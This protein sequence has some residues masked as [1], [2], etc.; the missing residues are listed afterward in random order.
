MRRSCFGPWLFQLSF[1]VAL[2][3]LWYLAT[4]QW[5]VAAILLPNPLRVWNQLALIA[6][7]GAFIH[8]LFVT[9]YEVV[10]AFVIAST[11]GLSIGYG[12]GRSAYAIRVFDPLFTSIYAVPVIL[13]VPLYSLLFGLGSAS[14]IALGVTIS[15]FP[16]ALNTMAGFSATDKVLIKAA[17]SF[18]ASPFHQF[19]Y[20]LLP[21]AF[22]TVLAGLRMG[23]ILAFLAVLGSE[24]LASFAGLGHK[25]VQYSETMETARMYAYI[26]IVV[27]LAGLL[28]FILS[29]VE[30]WGRRRD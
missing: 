26:I 12:V 19:R 7:T 24:T 20:V 22:P 2:F 8:P 29:G 16:I 17:R 1:I 21:S 4:T 10:V 30:K 23:M 18:G 11:T 15:F 5:N 9:L 14:K 6:K 3:I 25:I 13:F 27:A 28:N